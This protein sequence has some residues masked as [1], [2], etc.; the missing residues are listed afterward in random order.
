MNPWMSAGKNGAGHTIYATN[1]VF[2]YIPADKYSDIHFLETNQCPIVRLTTTGGCNVVTDINPTVVPVSSKAILAN[3][4]T[5]Q[6][7]VR[8]RV[9]SACMS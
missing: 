9:C 2:G 1:Q 7:G 3:I 6:D 4:Y 8:M 5:F